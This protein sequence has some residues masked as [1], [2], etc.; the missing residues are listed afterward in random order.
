MLELAS[1]ENSRRELLVGVA[2]SALGTVLLH[3]RRDELDQWS[4]RF[5]IWESVYARLKEGSLRA[6]SRDEAEAC[7]DALH[8]TQYSLGPTEL[9]TITG[10]TLREYA[11]VG[12]LLFDQ[13]WPV[14]KAVLWSE[15]E[16]RL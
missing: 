5:L 12:L 4:E 7:L 9:S 16:S 1:L 15:E 3:Y 2:R 10:F 13:L 6:M 8:I 14:Y 11:S